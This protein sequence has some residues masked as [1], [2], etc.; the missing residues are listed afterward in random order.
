MVTLETDRMILRGWRMEDLEDFFEYAKN[1]E[2]GPNAGWPPHQDKETSERILKGFIEKEEVW[3]IEDKH[4]GKVIGSLGVHED[5]KR[6]EDINARMIGYVLSR[7]FW[8]KGLMTEAVKK[9]LNYL[10]LEQKLDLVSCYHYSFNMKSKS[11]IQKCGFKYE[12]T[13]RCA[14]KIFD[15]SVYDDCCYSITREEYMDELAG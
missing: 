9:V 15:D 11:V 3:A 1:P 8:G 2:V 4:S 5:H 7:H 12:G 10:F 6:D 14:S 13:L